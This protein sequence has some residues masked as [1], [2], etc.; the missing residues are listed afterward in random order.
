[1]AMIHETALIYDNATVGPNSVIG[2]FV[3]L[4][5]YENHDTLAIGCRATIRS[6]TVIYAGTSIGR[7]FQSGHGVLIRENCRIGESVSVGSHSVLEHSVT[8]EDGARVHSGC[9]LPEL[10]TLERGA[11]LGPRVIVTNA[12]YPNRYDTK[13]KLE[14]VTVQ[15]GA[16]VGAGAVL[17]PGIVIGRKA[18]VGAGAVV[19]R[20]VE[21][22]SV[23]MG[24]PARKAF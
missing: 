19:T 14:G 9:F 12:K 23:V 21:S 13:D 16:V 15:E 22:G 7:E 5:S 1:M 11:W 3:I 18:L 17:L 24:N 10:T 8:I 20:D 2:A 6:H 4:G